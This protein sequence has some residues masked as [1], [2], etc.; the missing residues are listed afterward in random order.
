VKGQVASIEI[1]ADYQ[2]CVGS[3][4]NIGRKWKELESCK[5]EHSQ[6]GST[7]APTHCLLDFRFLL[8]HSISMLPLGSLITAQVCILDLLRNEIQN[9]FFGQSLEDKV[10]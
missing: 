5:I 6:V 2:Q 3:E 7:Q 8:S 4:R 1:L 9:D 10:L